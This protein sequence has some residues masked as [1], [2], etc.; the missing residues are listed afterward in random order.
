M[1]A[2]NP[3]A[4][5]HWIWRRFHEES[6]EWKERYEPLG[7]RMISMSSRENKFLPKQNLDEMLRK[8][9]SFV[10]RFVDAK[11]GIP[12]GQIH[13]V[14]ESSLI[15]GTPAIV[16]YIKQ[17]SVM[18][19]TMDH[20]DAAPTCVIAWAVDR[21]GNLIGMWEYYKPNLLVSD[22]R[23]NIAVLAG[24]DKF[25]FKLADP[26]IFYKTMQKYGGRWSFSDD[27]ADRNVNHGFD[28]DNAIFWNPAD[29]DEMGTRNLINE[30]LRPQG[31]GQ[32]HHGPEQSYGNL[33]VKA[34]EELPRVHPITGEYGYWPRL[35][36]ITKTADWPDGCDKAVLHT[37]SQRRER[38]GTEL[39]K[40]IFS[41]ERDTGIPDHAYDPVRYMVSSRAAGPG[42]KTA[43]YAENSFY[44]VRDKLERFKKRGGWRKLAER[45]SLGA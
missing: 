2:C 20:G 25:Q 36:F 14:R 31:N 5:T 30:Y 12:E 1:I 28:P 34:G 10:R 44:G 33:V 39:G 43:T 24:G 3:D 27:Y 37:R 18:H 38:V 8:D 19:M 9:D 13:N 11:W 32:I 23:R 45:V 7:Y 35:F 41:D 26:S 17:R 22:H 15:P 29:N 4:E 21:G 6:S 40:P 42:I 16:E